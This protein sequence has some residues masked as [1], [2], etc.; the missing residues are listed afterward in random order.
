MIDP[1]EV[2]R[3]TSAELDVPTWL[4]GGRLRDS[5]LGRFTLDTDVVVAGDAWRFAAAAA[6][7]AG[8]SFVALHRFPDVGR[9]VWSAGNEAVYLDVAGLAGEDLD[10]D[11]RQRDY[12]VNA[13][14]VAVH[15][16]L[17][18]SS[19]LVADPTGGLAD[20][21]ARTIRMT[22]RGAFAADPLRLLRGPRLA[23]QL[24]FQIEPLTAAQIRRQARLV[25][26]P[27]GERVRDELLSLLAVPAPADAVALLDRLGLLDKV[28]TEV[29]A[30]KKVRQSPPHHADVYHHSL[31][32]LAGLAD[33][34]QFVATGI[35]ALGETCWAS[36]LEP[37]SRELADWLDRPA[38]DA[39]RRAVLLRLAGMLHDVGKPG[40]AAVESEG[41]IRFIGH[42]AHSAEL[43]EGVAQR[44]RLSSSARRYVTT[45]VRWHT[46]PRQLAA[47]GG[48]SRRAIYRFYERAGPAGVDV[49]LHAVADTVAKEP[50]GRGVV[51][52]IAD[53]VSRL[54]SAWFERREE[55]VAPPPLV[56]GDELVQV[57]GITPGPA[58]GR[59]LRT[60]RE[61]QAAGEV[62][63]AD[64]ALALA[65][66]L[67][68]S[69]GN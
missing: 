68:R 6:R 28:L 35:G 9:V 34:E 47:A 52:A 36:V 1:L 31:E 54:L 58:V 21:R 67:L 13:M 29:A 18:P 43:A 33:V 8:G 26:R 60:I 24:G 66:Q 69:A 41:R 44:L 62:T 3:R 46:Q 4:V 51:P 63:T 37:H 64:Q 20:L 23:A 53:T 59:L 49:A 14:A 57:L 15:A 39:P 48:A 45:V 40:C 22:H 5:L 27:A 2:A 38:G 25:T 10:S 30:C 11:L 16:E 50:A 32:V 42:H 55:L 19:G 61:A 17:P 56:R 7:Q 65:R 12:T